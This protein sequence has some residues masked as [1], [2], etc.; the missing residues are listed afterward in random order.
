MV[1]WGTENWSKDL[2]DW[3]EKSI[4]FKCEFKIILSCFHVAK[5]CL[6]YSMFCFFYT[7]GCR[8]NIL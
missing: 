4:S 1:K 8:E 3:E 7:S 5:L 6:P 2:L